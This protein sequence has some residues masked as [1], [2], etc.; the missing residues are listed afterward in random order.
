MKFVIEK[1]KSITVKWTGIERI[2]KFHPKK[3]EK[4]LLFFFTDCELTCSSPF[5]RPKPI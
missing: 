2:N 5:K 3:R 1:K 4:E